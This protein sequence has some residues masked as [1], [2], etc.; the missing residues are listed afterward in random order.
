[1]LDPPTVVY[2]GGS[3]MGS[4]TFFKSPGNIAYAC[5]PILIGNLS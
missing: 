5:V 3:D 2:F 4:A 1:M